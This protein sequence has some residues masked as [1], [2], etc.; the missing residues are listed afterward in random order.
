M[1][2]FSKDYLAGLFDGEG[3]IFVQRYVHK[4]QK[5]MTY[6][7]KA[8]VCMT[9]KDL[10][11]ELCEE[12]D[13]F[14]IVHKKDEKNIKHSRAYEFNLTAGRAREFLSLIEPLLRVKGNEARAAIALHDDIS[15]YKGK[16]VR[17]SREAVM[18]RMNYRE[19]L[20][21][22]IKQAKGKNA[23]GA[24][25]N[26]GELGGH[27]MPGESAE[28]QYRTKQGL[29]ILGVR[30]EQVP[31]PKGKICSVLHGNMQ[32]AAEMTAPLRL[33]SGK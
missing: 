23:R 29:T 14:L 5:M 8:L 3:C 25:L 30:N 32:S 9:N 22:H 6:Y 27:P 18:E 2:G 21:W 28:G 1:S 31:E 7:L 33:V 11:L 15:A 26:S 19:A 10:I 24:I 20:Y 16:L 13:A 12:F 4:R 17:M